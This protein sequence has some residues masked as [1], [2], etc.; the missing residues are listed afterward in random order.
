M[1][2][3]TTQDDAKRGELSSLYSPVAAVNTGTFHSHSDASDCLK[4]EGRS[5]CHFHGV[6]LSRS[7]TPG[8]TAE[9][10]D[11]K[12]PGPVGLVRNWIGA[13]ALA[14]LG[15]QLEEHASPKEGKKIESRFWGEDG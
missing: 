4:A 11:H 7:K 1:S 8:N 3:C 13:L 10:L 6:W 14:F 5:E 15:E 12:P 2:S 9:T